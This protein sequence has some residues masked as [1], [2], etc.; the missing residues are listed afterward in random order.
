MRPSL[1]GAVSVSYLKAIQYL[2]LKSKFSISHLKQIQCIE[3]LL[4]IVS[5]WLARPT[6]TCVRALHF[7]ANK[8]QFII[9]LVR[10]LT[11]HF[12]SIQRSP[13]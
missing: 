9:H 6:S 13:I 5:L 7:Q 1:S 2:T 11:Y 12:I 10:V 4:L 8:P 3:V